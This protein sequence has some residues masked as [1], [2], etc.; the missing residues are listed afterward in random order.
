MKWLRWRMRKKER[1]REVL[2][3]RYLSPHPPSGLRILSLVLKV[4]FQ[5]HRSKPARELTQ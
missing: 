1:E 5:V 4:H 3:P 2:F